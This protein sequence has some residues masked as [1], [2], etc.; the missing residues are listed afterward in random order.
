MHL[1][2][3][4]ALAEGVLAA[5]P[6]HPAQQHRQNDCRRGKY[7]PQDR[8]AEH[9]KGQH[10]QHQCDQRDPTKDIEY[11]VRHPTAVVLS[12]CSHFDLLLRIRDTVFHVKTPSI[13]CLSF[14]LSAVCG[15]YF[16][17]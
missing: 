7:D 1:F 9:G 2:H 13:F 15:H 11:R 8:D 5:D 4:A 6:G 10:G 17:P 3:H 14:T 16:A 12:V